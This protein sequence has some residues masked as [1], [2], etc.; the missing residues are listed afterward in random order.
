MNRM[1]GTSENGQRQPV[2]TGV[3]DRADEAWGVNVQACASELNT[4][5]IRDTVEGRMVG[6][7]DSELG[8][9]CV[10]R[11]RILC[12]ERQRK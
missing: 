12:G 11:A 3:I 8:H 6:V 2:T 5:L 4:R 7:T 1:N 10:R 9:V